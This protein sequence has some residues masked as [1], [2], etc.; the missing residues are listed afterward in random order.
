MVKRIL[1]F[2]IVLIGT[3][4]QG[5]LFDSKSELA[6]GNYQEVKFR[7]VEKLKNIPPGIF[8]EF[9]PGV[10]TDFAAKEKV[11]A[12]TFDACGGPNGSRFDRDLIEFLKKEKIPATLFVTGLWIEK[13]TTVF[14]QL[15]NEPLF[16]IENHGQTHH[17]CTVGNESRYSIKG[18]GSVGAG[19]DEIELNA[20]QIQFYAHRKPEFY[21]PATAATDEG[22]VA[23]AMELKERIVSY[24]LL[25]GD[26]VAGL[27]AETIKENILKKAKSGGIVIMHMNHPEWN[28]FEALQVAIPV[29]R[30]EGYQ[31]VKLESAFR[32]AK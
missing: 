8:G 20:R 24:S 4:A 32:L 6:S 28:G 25:S 23:I 5:Q 12:L 27:A 15:C 11:L 19:F 31:F 3:V 18:T 16:E 17:P 13:N 10:I 7:I 26:A 29:L 30:Q 2:T 21:R 22:C 9:I 14:Q 1:P